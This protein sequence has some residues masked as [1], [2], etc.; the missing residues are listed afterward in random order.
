MSCKEVSGEDGSV[1]ILIM[2]E[3]WNQFKDLSHFVLNIYN[4]IRLRFKIIQQNP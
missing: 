2:K 3:W 1:D 4:T